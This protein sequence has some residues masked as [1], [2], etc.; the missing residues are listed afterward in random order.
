MLAGKAANLQDG[1]PARFRLPRSRPPEAA[2][3]PLPSPAQ[4]PQDAVK[5]PTM[6]VPLPST[7]LRT[8]AWQKI[9][10]SK[11]A[12]PAGP[13]PNIWLQAAEKLQ[14]P[15]FATPDFSKLEHLFR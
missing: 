5:L 8:F 7:K 9:S 14:R 1:S 3:V 6:N 2:R 15:G 4:P 12:H 13:S 11:V 10:P